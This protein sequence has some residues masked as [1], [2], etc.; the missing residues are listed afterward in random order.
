MVHYAATN[1]PHQLPPSSATLC[2]SHMHNNVLVCA[3]TSAYVGPNKSEISRRSWYA[4]RRHSG[5]T[6]KSRC[7]WC[8]VISFRNFLAWSPPFSHARTGKVVVCSI[9]RSHRPYVTLWPMAYM[10]S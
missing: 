9:F 3:K 8:R 6:S 7:R 2:R 1:C 5:Q 4:K 10:I